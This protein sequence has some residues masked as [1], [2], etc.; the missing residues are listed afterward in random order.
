MRKFRKLLYKLRLTCS[1]FSKA[2][3]LQMLKDQRALNAT[4]QEK[5]SAKPRRRKSTKK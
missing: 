5:V 3:L 4:L 2:G 1:P